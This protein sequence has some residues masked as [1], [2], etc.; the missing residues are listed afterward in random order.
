M[1]LWHTLQFR[2]LRLL[3]KRQKIQTILFLLTNLDEQELL[4]YKPLK[5][6]YAV[7]RLISAYAGS[8]GNPWVLKH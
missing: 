5:F 7:L 3:F 8:V 6:N 4:N 2:S 1:L